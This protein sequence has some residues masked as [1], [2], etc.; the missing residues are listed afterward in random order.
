MY[1]REASLKALAITCDEARVEQVLNNLMSNAIKYSSPGKPVVAG[2]EQ[3]QSNEVIVWVRDQGPGIGQEEQAHIFDRF[4]RSH[5]YE[6]PGVEGLGLGLYIA[7][8][9]VNRHGGRMWLASKP[10]A[11]STFYFSLPLT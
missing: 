4:Y 1:T 8:E 5:A 6:N 3:G 9:I 7:H 10:E 11:G 2:V